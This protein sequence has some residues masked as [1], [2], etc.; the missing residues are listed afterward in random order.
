MMGE[1]RSNPKPWEWGGSQNIIALWNAGSL[2]L[3]DG[4]INQIE[5][6]GQIYF[7][8][9]S[10]ILRSLVYFIFWFTLRNVPWVS[11]CVCVCVHIIDKAFCF[12]FVLAISSLIVISSEMYI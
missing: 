3:K 10:V 5:G 7:L 2:A 6:W 11:L 12:L 8:H 4:I 9:P 1:Q